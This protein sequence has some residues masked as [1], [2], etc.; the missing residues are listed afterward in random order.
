RGYRVEEALISRDQLYA[1]DEVF[2]CGTAAEVV[3]LREID[4]RRVGDGRMGPVTR[5][6][7]QAYQDAVRG[8]LADHQNWCE[9]V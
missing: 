1:A 9:F 7:Q 8:G 6:L 2:V 3:G 5:A 4:F